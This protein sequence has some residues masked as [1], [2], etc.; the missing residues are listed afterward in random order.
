[1]YWNQKEKIYSWKIFSFNLIWFKRTKCRKHPKNVI[2]FSKAVYFREKPCKHSFDV[3]PLK[4]ERKL[5][6]TFFQQFTRRLSC[7]EMETSFV[8]PKTFLSHRSFNASTSKT[9]LN[10]PTSNPSFIRPESKSSLNVSNSNSK[11]LLSR[12][13]SKTSFISSTSKTSLNVPTSKTSLNVPNLKRET[14]LSRQTVVDVHQQSTSPCRSATDNS[15]KNKKTERK[16]TN[17]ISLWK[18]YYTSDQRSETIYL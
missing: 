15:L 17:T 12:R 8:D 13:S 18:P 6:K 14:F 2:I 5:L 16:I 7:R 9:S 4:N 1:M 10:V 11:S 3:F